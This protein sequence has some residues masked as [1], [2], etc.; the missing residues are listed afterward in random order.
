MVSRLKFKFTTRDQSQFYWFLSVYVLSRGS[1]WI[2]L[3]SVKTS[4]VSSRVANHSFSRCWFWDHGSWTRIE[5]HSLLLDTLV[6]PY[7]SWQR[8]RIQPNSKLVFLKMIRRCRNW[9]KIVECEVD[10]GWLYTAQTE[11]SKV[12]RLW[13]SHIRFYCNAHWFQLVLLLATWVYC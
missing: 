9:S 11:R 5:F 13:L 8:P 2:C 3:P 1:I 7:L 12:L 6:F 4:L 10:S